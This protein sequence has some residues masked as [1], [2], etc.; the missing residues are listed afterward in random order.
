MW[1]LANQYVSVAESTGLLS[2]VCFLAIIVYCFK[3]LGNARKAAED[4]QQAWFL[5]LLG[6]TLFSNLIAFLGISYFDQ[7]FV[8]WYA[9]LAM[10]VAMS[11]WPRNEPTVSPAAAAISELSA[12]D[13]WIEDRAGQT[14][15]A[16]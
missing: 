11:A 15:V 9:V 2:F 3:Y 1:D 10:I 8:V 14:Q 12:F 13:Q 4:R 7:T 5:W 6:V 16:P